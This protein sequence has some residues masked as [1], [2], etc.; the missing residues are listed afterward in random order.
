MLFDCFRYPRFDE[1]GLRWYALPAVSLMLFD[2]GGLEFTGAPF[3]GWY[4]GTEIGARDLCDTGRLNM[5]K[6]GIISVLLVIVCMCIRGG[7]DAWIAEWSKAGPVTAPC[8]SP[9][10]HCICLCWI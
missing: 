9:L 1:L 10:H 4:M 3:N 6:V 7:G 8:L 2:C 5:L